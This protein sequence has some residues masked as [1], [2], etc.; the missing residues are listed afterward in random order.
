M[1]FGEVESN[2]SVQVY[3]GDLDPNAIKVELY[4][5]TKIVE[6]KYCGPIRDGYIYQAAIPSDLFTPRIVPY[7]PGVTTLETPQILWQR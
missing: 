5:A 2:G 6:M 7:F 3:L 1:R 4:S